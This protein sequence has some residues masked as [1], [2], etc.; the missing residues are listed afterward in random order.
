MAQLSPSV[1]RRIAASYAERWR[2][3]SRSALRQATKEHLGRNRQVK[4]RT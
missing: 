3:I 2:S 1:V 4:I